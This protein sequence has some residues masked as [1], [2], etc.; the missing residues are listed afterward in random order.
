MKRWWLLVLIG[1]AVLGAAS[2][3]MAQPQPGLTISFAGEMYTIGYAWD[4][5]T[6]FTDSGSGRFRDSDSRLLQRGRLF[7]TVQSADKKARAVWAIEIG[8]ITFGAGGGASGA[9]YGGTT[10]RT[11]PGQGGE[12]GAD[13]VNVETKH[14]FL[15][16]DLPLVPN[17]SLLLG[18]H[19][20]VFLPGPAGPFSGDDGAGIQLGWKRGP[21][22]LQMYTV[23][24]AEQDLASADDNTLYAAR[25]GLSVTKDLRLTV[26]G[27]VVDQQCFARRAPVAPATTGP[28]VSADFG[29]TFWVGGTVA[30]T[31]GTLKLDG[32]VVYGRRQLFSATNNASVEESGWG[33]QASARF[34][35][36]PIEAWIHG[37]YT[38]ADDNR[39]PG[40]TASRVRA[41]GPGQDFSTASNTTKLNQ[42]SDK[43]PVPIKRKSWIGA[44]FQ[45]EALLGHRTFGTPSL[46]QPFDQDPS[47]T[48]GIGAS[49]LYPL[50][51]AVSL[52][53]GVAYVAA[54]EHNGIFGDDAVEVDA[55]VLYSY[56]ANLSIQ[57]V[58]SYIV[59][60]AGDGAWAV[61]FRTRFAF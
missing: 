32:T 14:A 44:P 55:G 8:D 36:G 59:P 23:K 1:S 6:D 12:L 45:A 16:F 53:G 15:Q 29:D 13:G 9:D 42:D 46:G 25:V 34:P 28:C 43:L 54:S 58:G 20:F 30:A 17:A 57:V 27:L 47:G 41:P 19:P 35:V 38:T 31:V 4:N 61:G 11:G 2:A 48:W 60:E 22:D 24:A 56:N 5:V 50:T 7:T 21:I 51:Q 49:G 18:I 3:A 33:A 52:G 26:E 40:S 37:W 39:I 10:V